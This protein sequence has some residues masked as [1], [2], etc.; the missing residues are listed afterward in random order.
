VTYPHPS[1]EPVL[2]DTYGVILFQEQVL[3]IAH[4]FAGL[5]LAQADEFRR[6]MSRFRDAEEME[7]MAPA[8]CGAPC[9][10][11]ALRRN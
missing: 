5:S 1:L 2:R 9:N 10:N 4:V 3:E 11:M 6:L 8:S 7:G